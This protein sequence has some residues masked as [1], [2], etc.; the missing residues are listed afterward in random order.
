MN[1]TVETYVIKLNN[2]RF[3]YVLNARLSHVDLYKLHELYV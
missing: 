2:A 1:R 3:I